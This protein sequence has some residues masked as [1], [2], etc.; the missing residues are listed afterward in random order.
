AKTN[1]IGIDNRV[2]YEET[3]VPANADFNSRR[4]TR[5]PHKKDKLFG[6]CVLV[7]LPDSSRSANYSNHKT[8]YDF[9]RF[10]NPENHELA[11]KFLIDMS[12]HGYMM[13]AK[14]NYGSQYAKEPLKATKTYT[15][16]VTVEPKMKTQVEDYKMVNSFKKN[17]SLLQSNDFEIIENLQPKDD[18]D[19]VAGVC[20]S[21]S[22][23]DGD[24]VIVYSESI[25]SSDSEDRKTVIEMSTENEFLN[26]LNEERERSDKLIKENKCLSVKTRVKK[27]Q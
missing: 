21:N 11:P 25:Y 1:R 19:C 26:R 3:L 27:E 20:V 22:G 16:T 7:S 6:A 10:E 15:V 23:S 18:N 13:K 4:S 2:E 14:V 9:V 17:Q 8:C 12:F 5:A 24:V